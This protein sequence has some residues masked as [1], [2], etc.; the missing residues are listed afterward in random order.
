[1][2]KDLIPSTPDEE[3]IEQA[4]KTFISMSSTTAEA[5]K[6]IRDFNPDLQGTESL[7]LLQRKYK[8]II[9]LFDI[10]PTKRAAYSP[11]GST[12]FDKAAT[13]YYSLLSIL[14]LSKW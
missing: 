8:Y 4:V 14:I 10:D 3:I 1:M 12:D 9:K 7:E 5:D 2:G 11:P 6:V 13:D